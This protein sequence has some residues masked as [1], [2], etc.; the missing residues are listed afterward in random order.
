MVWLRTGDI[1]RMDDRGYVFIEDRK[2]DIIIVSGFKVFP[3]RLRML[4]R[5]I[6]EWPKWPQ[7]RSRTQNRAKPLQ[8]LL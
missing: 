8:Y 2:K 3:T 4:S 5:I 1:G 6:P 7:S